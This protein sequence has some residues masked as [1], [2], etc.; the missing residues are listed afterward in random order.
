MKRVILFGAPGAGKGTQAEFIRSRMGFVKVA[1]GDLIRSE[2][3]TQSELGLRMR[4]VIEQGELVPDDIIIEIV[5]KR[6][7]LGDI[8]E[9]YILD[10]F[11]RTIAQARALD[12]LPAQKEYVFYMK[13]GDPAKVVG[14]VVTRLTCAVCGAT[15]SMLTKPPKTEGVCDL[16]QGELVKRSD[17]QEQTIRQRIQIY[18]RETKPVIEYFRRVGS[19][20]EIDASCDIEKVSGMIEGYLK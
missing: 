20:I 9:G 2:V 10:G 16:C 14:R 18:R 15:F 6:L 4:S 17:D 7:E 13:I 12:L 11:P 5:K 3:K 19:L 1:T 8:R